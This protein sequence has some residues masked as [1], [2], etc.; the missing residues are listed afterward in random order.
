MEKPVEKPGFELG[1][2]A[3]ARLLATTDL[4]RIECWADRA[5]TA[6]SLDAVFSDD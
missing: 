1:A 5:L 4:D 3:E 2:D 6:A